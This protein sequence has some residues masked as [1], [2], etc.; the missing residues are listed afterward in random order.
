MNAVT[1]I[2]FPLSAL[3]AHYALFTALALL[4]G[5]CIGSF[6]NA[7]IYRIPH[8][9]S[10]VHP[11]SFCPVCRA[12]IAWYDNVPVLGWLR[13]GGRC[14][15]CRTFISPRYLLV[16]C[17][18]GV[19]F[20]LVWLKFD[21]V[22]EGRV[23]GLDPIV[24]WPLVPVYWLVLA[25]LVLGT[26]VDFE[27]L[28]IPDRVTLGGIAAGL[29]LSVVVPSLHGADTWLG[30]L[31]RGVIG[32]AAGWGLLWFVARAGRLVFKKEA[33]GFGD[34]KLLGAIGAFLGWRAV[35]FTVVVSSLLGA[36]VGIALVLSRRRELQSRIPYGPYLALAAAVW[37]Y[38]GPQLWRL[39]TG[40]LL[41]SP[42]L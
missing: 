24:Q 5:L 12:K 4:W 20:L 31:A 27:H 39:Y 38:W 36:L 30:G 28:I 11:R 23:L 41:G 9:L 22:A 34:V 29:I 35:L 7:C 8:G 19:L 1:D 33:M 42:V 16:E 15:A 2:V 10:V 37:V 21:L 32:A 25:G 3:P 17:L 18:V 6:L 14:R 40:L 26:F 13:L